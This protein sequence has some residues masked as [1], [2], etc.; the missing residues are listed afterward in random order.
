[1]K[2]MP[3]GTYFLMVELPAGLDLRY[4]YSLGDGFWNSELT[5]DGQF[6]VRQLIVPDADLT[7]SDT[8]ES[9]GSQRSWPDYFQRESP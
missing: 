6:H 2:S 1:M 9:W 5:N 8:I 4:K 7:I 3:D